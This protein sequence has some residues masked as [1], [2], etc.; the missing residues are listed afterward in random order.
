M[1]NASNQPQQ[2]PPATGGTD[3]EAL[4]RQSQEQLKKAQDET[5][6]WKAQSR[7][8][9]NR[10]K[11]N[12][13]AAKDLEEVNQQMTDLSQRLAAAEGENAALK[14]KAARTALVAKVAEATGVSEAIVASLAANDEESLTAAATAIAEAYKTP[15]GAPSAPEA[16]THIQVGAQSKDNADK[17][18]ELFNSQLGI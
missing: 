5:E 11:A 9:E 2:E 6:K 3:F 7:K 16:G 17:F 10:A 12:Y 18:I 8:N 14:A 15:G 13:G 1:P 4:Y